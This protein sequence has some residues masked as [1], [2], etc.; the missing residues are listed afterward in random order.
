MAGRVFF[1]PEDGSAKV[2]ITEGVQALYDLVTSSMDWG[3]GF[4]TV[5]DALPVVHVARTCGFEGIAEAER[6]VEFQRAQE[7]RAA[8]LRAKREAQSQQ[9]QAGM[10]GQR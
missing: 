6:Y 2:D 4:L 8:E 1:E 9:Q 7:V 3:S 10:R 5:E